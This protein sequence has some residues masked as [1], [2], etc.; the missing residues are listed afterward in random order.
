M[1]LGYLSEQGW[2]Q[3]KLQVKGRKNQDVLNDPKVDPLFKRKILSIEK[4]KKFFYEFFK[5]KETSI[6]SETTFLD[7]E[8][9]TYLLIASPHKQMVPHEFDFPF[10]G[11]FP[12]I[13]FF[14][15]D[16]AKKFAKKLEEDENLVTWIRPVYAYST[17]GYLEDRILSSFFHFEDIELSE[18]VFHELFHT[19]FFMKDDVDL[20]EN[21]AQF[22]SRRLLKE[23][24]GENADYQAYQKL[25]A[26]KEKATQK[27]IA[28]LEL[29]DQEFKK[30]GVFLS[31]EK[32]DELT[33]RFV[34]EILKPVMKDFCDSIELPQDECKVKKKWNQ[35]TFAALLTYEKDQEFFEELYRKKNM[36]LI[37]YYLWLKSQYQVYETMKS[38]ELSFKSYLESAL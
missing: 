15:K 36:T 28:T 35:A 2:G 31:D 19:I 30:L 7:H 38:K 9:V 17:L 34:L 13:G 21:L 24:Y 27:I 1:S 12:Y 3:L 10:M 16:S 29:L 25:E 14:S 23:Y 26:K 37:N 6:Y 33:E 18:L 20:N 4:D 11:K 5:E 22:F 32:A 8:A